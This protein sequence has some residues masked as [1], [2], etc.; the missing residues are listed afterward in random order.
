MPTGTRPGAGC[1]F[2]SA[3]SGLPKK[4]RFQ[5]ATGLGAGVGAGD[6]AAAGSALGVATAERIELDNMMNVQRVLVGAA[7]PRK[8]FIVFR[9]E[10]GLSTRSM[11]SVLCAGGSN[12]LY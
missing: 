11:Y 4:G 3:S 7:A 6:G 8:V 10:T 5:K 12:L 1:P 2:R 9:L